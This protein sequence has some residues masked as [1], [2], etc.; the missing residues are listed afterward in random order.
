MSN[1][2]W[3]AEQG[4]PDVSEWP[5]SETWYD[6]RYIYAHSEFTPAQTM[7]GKQALYSYLH[8]LGDVAGPEVPVTGVELENTEM[9][10][11]GSEEI[12]PGYT[13]LPASATNKFVTWESSDETIVKVDHNGVITG[14]SEGSADIT[15]MTM[16]G[17]FVDQVN[18]TV[19]NV[20]VTGINI[21]PSSLNL[22]AGDK[23]ILEAQVLPAN[24][25]NKNISWVSSEDG[26]A[27][28]DDNG[29]VT[30]IA[31]GNAVITATTEDGSFSAT[32]TVTIEALPD[33]LAIY[34]DDDQNYDYIWEDNAVRT[35]LE[36]GGYEGRKHMQF[37]YAMVN[38]WSGM[39]IGYNT[40]IDVSRYKFLM[41]AVDGPDSP[42]NIY[43]RLDDATGAQINA[44][45]L[46]RSEKYRHYRISLAEIT[47]STPIDLSSL[48]LIMIGM[49][50]SPDATGT[51]HIDDI[52]FTASAEDVPVTA[53][54]VSP[55][56]LTLDADLLT[57]Q[58]D[59]IVSPSTA[60]N[61]SVSWTSLD[62]SIA[63]I[64]A[65]GKVEGQMTG[66]TGM[67]VETLDGAFKDTTLVTVP[68]ISVTGISLKPTS[69]TIDKE[70]TIQLTATIEPARATN[71]NVN[72][73]SEDNTIA[74]VS[75]GGLVTGVE[76]GTVMITATSEEGDFTARAEITVLG[77]VG[78]DRDNI[79]EFS[80]YPNPLDENDPGFRR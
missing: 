65:Y 60:T 58:L 28:V 42:A 24:A 9:T 51:F 59:A 75:P 13:V 77:N 74:T 31:P 27:E 62:E 36:S 52:Y 40:P 12:K 18:V 1:P 47:A 63:T 41:L 78:L 69:K 49:A 26:I 48:G 70:K 73:N 38:W 4:Y 54:E 37:D 80:I 50:G 45:H 68:H 14:V 64:D 43:I 22:L 23:G 5:K 53:V 55:E 79:H 10:L 44:V 39:G 7:R 66:T 21:V 35:E 6:V 33:Q 20:S 61:K 32:C 30:G 11:E 2:I 76:E 34:R 15:I 8:A 29:T 17:G 71:K 25:M 19:T 46:P 67:V 3:L 57:A 56:E 72:W 16:D